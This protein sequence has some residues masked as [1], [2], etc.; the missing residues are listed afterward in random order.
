M[1]LALIG[2]SV[3][4]HDG[5]SLLSTVMLSLVSSFVGFG[6]HWSLVFKEPTVSDERHKAIPRS[7]VII[8]YPNGSIRVIRP[9]SE[10]IARLYF[11]TEH[12]QY[13]ID[14]TPYRTLALFSTV[15]FMAGVVSLAN[16]SNILQVAFAAAYILLNIVHWAVSA[17]NPCTYHWQHAYDVEVLPIAP[18]QKQG[19]DGT[20]APATVQYIKEKI[21]DEW[22]RFQSAWI[23]EKRRHRDQ[24]R[25]KTIFV[26]GGRNFTAALWTAIVLTGTAQWLNEAT[27]IAPVNEAWKEW[28]KEAQKFAQPK[29]EEGETPGRHNDEWEDRFEPHRRPRI[30]TGLKWTFTPALKTDRR[31]V[32]QRRIK[33]DKSWKYQDRL[34]EILAA[35]APQTRVQLEDEVAGATGGGAISEKEPSTPATTEEV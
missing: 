24:E 22:R 6:T 31:A 1:S 25:A 26:H 20:S 14:D 11:Q 29:V 32:R 17:L 15:M 19:T 9:E 13:V 7:D 2:L 23:L 34:T 10:Q 12:A 8:Y 35:H 33:I 28:L 16:A 18:P 5:F 3:H 4:Y 21:V 30:A 27:T